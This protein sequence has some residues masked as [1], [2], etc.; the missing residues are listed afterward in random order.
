MQSSTLVSSFAEIAHEKD[1]DR[2]ALQLIM[3]DVFRAMINKR[4]GALAE[5]IGRASCRERV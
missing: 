4:Y 2:D 5:E 1:I 3:E